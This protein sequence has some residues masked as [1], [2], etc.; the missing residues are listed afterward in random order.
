M[1]PVQAEKSALRRTV[2]AR[3]RAMD[4]A[5]R[6]SS[7]REIRRRASQLPSYQDCTVF[8]CFVGAGW[9]VDTSPWIAQALAEGRRVSV[10]LC[11]GPGI[12][13]A[14]YIRSLEDLRPGAWGIPEP[15]ADNPLCPPAEISFAAVPCVACGRDGIRLGRGG[16]YY[17]R[18][19]AGSPFPAAVLCRETALLDRIPRAPWD[20]PADYVVTESRTYPIDKTRR[21]SHGGQD[22]H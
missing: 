14:R 8:F 1:D 6:S 18:F 19:L 9:E 13:E 15:P 17:D 2:L 16:G 21:T 22:R 3:L 10:P 11:V 5:E 7:D 4:P 20:R 12:M